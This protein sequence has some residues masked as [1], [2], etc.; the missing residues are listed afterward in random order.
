VRGNCDMTVPPLSCVGGNIL[1]ETVF[2]LDGMKLLLTH[3]HKYGA[4]NGLGRLIH[5]AAGLEVDG[6]I[7][8][9]LHQKLNFVLQPEN[10]YTPLSKPLHIFNPGSIG[11]YPHT[12]GSLTLRDGIPLFGHGCID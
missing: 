7:F 12:F 10:E 9:H 4:K 6:V 2:T 5:H 1:D 11:Y 8:G 3:G